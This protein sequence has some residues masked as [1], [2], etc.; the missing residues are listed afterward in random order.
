MQQKIRIDS[1]A[2]SKNPDG[3]WT[4]TKNTDIDAPIGTIR[5]P[6]DM[7]FKKGITFYGIDVAALLDQ[8][9]QSA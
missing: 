2:F 4:S 5:F 9:T 6:H 3:S 7:P 8:N 1:Q